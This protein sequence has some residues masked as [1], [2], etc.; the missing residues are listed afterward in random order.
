M[1]KTMTFVTVAKKNDIKSGQVKT[2]QVGDHRIVLADWEGTYFA[3]QDLCSHDG[4]PLGD[5]ELI[6][7]E[8][9]CPRHG[10]RFDIRTGQVTALPPLMPIKTFPVRVQGDDIQVALS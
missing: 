8:I 2:F 4:G 3:T 1:D 7:F 5:G 10:G 6:E 9:E